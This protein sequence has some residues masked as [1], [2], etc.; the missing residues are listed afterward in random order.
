MF[1]GANLKTGTKIFTAFTLMCA[2]FGPSISLAHSDH[3]RLN[4]GHVIKENSSYQ[5]NVEMTSK[6]A[7]S[8]DEKE[9]KEASKAA[10]EAYIPAT[11]VS[12][13]SI[14]DKSAY[15]NQPTINQTA[16]NK[17][18]CHASQMQSLIGQNKTVLRKLNFDGLIRVSGPNTIFTKE[19]D[20]DRVNFITDETGTIQQ[21]TCG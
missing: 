16:E 10:D 7:V 18:A 21:I 1:F 15:Y 11:P 9:D 12:A 13:S 8:I 6:D 17:D 3:V 5:D 19:Y 2:S 20:P 4:G 14:G